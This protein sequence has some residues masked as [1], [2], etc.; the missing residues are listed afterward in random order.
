MHY[1]QG[2][3]EG[4]SGILFPQKIDN[5]PLLLYNYLYNI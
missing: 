2:D 4:S 5:K 3:H 1:D